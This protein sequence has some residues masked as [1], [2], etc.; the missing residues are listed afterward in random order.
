MVQLQH[1]QQGLLQGAGGVVVT[2]LNGAMRVRSRGRDQKCPKRGG[3][4]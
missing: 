3:K 4:P 1:L 2:L